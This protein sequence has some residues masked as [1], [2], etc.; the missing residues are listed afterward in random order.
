M[1]HVQI[2]DLGRQRT[3]D[4]ELEA[5]SRGPIEADAARRAERISHFRGQPQ[6]YSS[7]VAKI[8]AG[9]N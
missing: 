4:R 5:G 9:T 7:L 3:R 2:L 6:N 1:V 8:P